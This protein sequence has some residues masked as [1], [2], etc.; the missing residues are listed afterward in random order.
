MLP[1]LSELNSDAAYAARRNDIELWAPWAR[2]ALASVGLPQPRTLTVPG[3]STNPVVVGDNGMVVK[4]FGPYWS[5]PESLVSE[6]EAYRVLGGQPLPV[7]RLLARGELL[8]GE[9]GWHW[10][11]LVTSAVAGRPWRQV[12]ATAGRATALR[13]A[14]SAGEL[15]VGLRAVPLVETGVLGYDAPEFAEMLRPRRSATVADH[16][17]WGYLSPELLAAVEG[18]LPDVDDL[19]DG[20][21]PVFVHGDLN[22]D[23]LFAD[24]ERGEITGLID[25]NDVYAGD[26]RYSLVQLH[27]NA[28]RADRELLGV[29]LAA[30]EFEVTPEFPRAMLAFTFLH[31]FEVLEEVPFDLTGITDIDELA[32][33][34]WGVH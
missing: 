1:D 14:R 30:A 16:R 10:P 29:A 26:F 5:G 19:I 4:F 25:F 22:A 17:G 12:L 13:L 23:N 31:D 28:F 20:A 34:L 32:E 8:P 15:L 21:A 7:P 27:L 3:P 2:H 33:T 11:F 6:T 24:P 9:S 18:F